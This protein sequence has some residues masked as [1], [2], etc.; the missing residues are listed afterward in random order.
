MARKH[1]GFGILGAVGL[2]AGA[3]AGCGG[4]P[5]QAAAPPSSGHHTSKAAPASSAV[6]SDAAAAS[7]VVG[8]K[9]LPKASPAKPLR[10]LVIGDS[11]GEDLQNGLN[12][13]AGSNSSMKITAAAYGSSGLVNLA[14]HNWPKIF[15][16]DLAV[17]HPQ[18]VYVLFGAND[19]YSYYQNNQAVVFGGALWRKDYG[20]RVNTILNEAAR[21]HAHVI[22][23]GLPIMST[24]SVLSNPKMQTLN[25][26][27]KAEVKRHKAIAAFVPTWKLFQNAAGQFTQYMNDSAG[28]SVMVRDPDGVH[29]A[30]TAG[31]ELIASY[32]LYHTE[33]LEKVSLCVNGQDVW[34]QYPLRACS[35]KP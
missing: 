16:H 35:T 17:Y 5:A 14:Y 13:V 19:S 27:Y 11:L 3:A 24:S 9:P 20:G 8:I 6:A 34:T 28:T 12:Y 33:K 32:V 26:L 23:V 2:L 25:G 10:V 15:A 7:R 29:I 31:D 22:W 30:P 1:L 18:L 21:A 4:S